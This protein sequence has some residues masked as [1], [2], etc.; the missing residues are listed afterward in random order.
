L[1][2]SS[3]QTRP[4]EAPVR[5]VPGLSVNHTSR[6]CWYRFRNSAKKH[7]GSATD[8]NAPALPRYLPI[9][10]GAS[11]LKPPEAM[12]GVL[13]NRSRMVQGFRRFGT[14]AAFGPFDPLH[15]PN[16]DHLL[17]FSLLP[18]LWSRIPRGLRIAFRWKDYRSNGPGRWKT[19]Q[20]HPHEFIQALPA[21][22]YCP[23]AST[24]SATTALC[25]RHPR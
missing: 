19:M 10:T 8:Q 11:S 6:V 12:L 13:T 18:T 1:A 17:T 20:L 15:P 3:L 24:A 7:W 5:P 16:V 2:S 4:T 22:T 23:R 14:S 9:S 21:W 25:Q